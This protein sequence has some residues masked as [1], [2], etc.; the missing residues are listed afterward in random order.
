FSGRGTRGTYEG[1]QKVTFP[2]GEPYGLWMRTYHNQEAQALVN[3]LVHIED[4]CSKNTNE[5]VLASY[6]HEP[7]RRAFIIEKAVEYVDSGLE[8]Q[9]PGLG[10]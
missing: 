3:A 4:F 9:M 6:V 5:G 10:L 1:F 8:I 7:A 2:T